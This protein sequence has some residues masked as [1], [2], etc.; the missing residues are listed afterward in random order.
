MKCDNE[1]ILNAIDTWYVN[2]RTYCLIHSNT[3][4]GYIVRV[5]PDSDLDQEGYWLEGG[6]WETESGAAYS[7]LC[8]LDDRK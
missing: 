6:P 5:I 3:L 2:Y 8:S 1:Y 4:D 7:I